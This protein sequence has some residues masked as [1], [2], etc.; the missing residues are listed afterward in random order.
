MCGRLYAMIRSAVRMISRI[1]SD[2]TSNQIGKV[3]KRIRS[4]FRGV[5]SLES[6][7]RIHKNCGCRCPGTTIE[8]FVLTSTTSWDTP[9]RDHYESRHLSVG[10]LPTHSFG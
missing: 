5:I 6:L 1:V 7:S 3:V 9:L 10:G 2:V 4:G 8:W